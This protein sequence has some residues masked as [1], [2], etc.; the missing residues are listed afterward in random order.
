[1]KG[2][3][4]KMILAH[5]LFCVYVAIMFMFLVLWIRHELRQTNRH[6]QKGKSPLPV[7][8]EPQRHYEEEWQQQV[9]EDEAQKEEKPEEYRPQYRRDEDFYRFSVDDVLW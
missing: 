3:V 6:Q 2:L 8:R 7:V 4:R 5:V 1:M 9:T